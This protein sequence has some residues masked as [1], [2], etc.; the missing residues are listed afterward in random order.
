MG[1]G[2]GGPR[3]TTYTETFQSAAASYVILWHK[4]LTLYLLLVMCFFSIYDI[5]VYF[6]VT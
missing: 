6:T 5:D 1:R 3:F 2:R 4:T